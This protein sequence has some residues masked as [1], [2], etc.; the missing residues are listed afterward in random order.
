[1]LKCVPLSRLSNRSA[2]P[3]LYKSFVMK[4]TFLEHWSASRVTNL[5]IQPCY[6]HSSVHRGGSSPLAPPLGFLGKGK[7]Q[8][9]W[10]KKRACPHHQRGVS[11]LKKYSLKFSW[12]CFAPFIFKIYL[13][14]SLLSKISTPPYT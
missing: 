7:N 11:P 10:V 12:W 1:M 3:A 8:V 5:T 6:I 9:F 2:S 13:S 14:I 4:T